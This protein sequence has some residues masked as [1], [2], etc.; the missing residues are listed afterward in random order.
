VRA[1]DSNSA[2]TLIT[3][4]GSLTSRFCTLEFLV[5]DRFANKT[6]KGLGSELVQEL[7]VRDLTVLSWIS[8]LTGW[9]SIE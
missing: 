2:R 8:L 5:S 9:I 3:V 7:T 6:V 4:S 1:A